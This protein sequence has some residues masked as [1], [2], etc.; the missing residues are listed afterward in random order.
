MQCL[1]ARRHQFARSTAEKDAPRGVTMLLLQ[2]DDTRSV[3]AKWPYLNFVV[4]IR[5]AEAAAFAASST[6][7]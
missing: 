5:T 4:K 7:S 1:A 3:D 2:W 6:R